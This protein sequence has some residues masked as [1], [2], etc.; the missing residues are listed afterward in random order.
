MKND[1]Q[2]IPFVRCKNCEKKSVWRKNKILD[3][4][5]YLEYKC[6]N[7]NLTFRMDLQEE[8]EIEHIEKEL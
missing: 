7:C 1:M 6:A 3:Y 8:R 2:Y 5:D 4:L